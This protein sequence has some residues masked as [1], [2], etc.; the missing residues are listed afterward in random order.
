MPLSETLYM[1][2]MMDS[3]RNQFGVRYPFDGEMQYVFERG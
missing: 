1:M 3:I 2:D